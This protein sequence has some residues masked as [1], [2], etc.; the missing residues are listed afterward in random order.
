MG[1]FGGDST[2][3][4]TTNNVS[5]SAGSQT[6]NAPSS[7]VVSEGNVTIN[8]V[9]TDL[10]SLAVAEGIAQD[11]IS[12]ITTVTSDALFNLGSAAGDAVDISLASLDV[13][14][15]VT[16]TALDNSQKTTESVIAGA[17]NIV[18]DVIFG[19]ASAVGDA[20]GL[21]E[22]VASDAIFAVGDAYENSQTNAF[23]FAEGIALEAF[24]VI[25][26]QSA[27]AITLATD[28]VYENTSLVDKV[29]NIISNFGLKSIASAEQSA[30]DAIASAEAA[31]GRALEFGNDA[32]DV[33]SSA[34][35]DQTTVTRSVIDLADDVTAG[36]Q[37]F[38]L[39]ALG[40]AVNT[41]EEL[42]DSRSEESQN[43]LA[44]VTKLGETVSTGGESLRVEANKIFNLAMIAVLGFVAVQAMRG[45]K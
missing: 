23:G 39:E 3:N 1:L 7:S 30:R 16:F 27:G 25:E 15:E 40:T 20:L 12:G 41:I 9:T 11:A 35:A 29:S 34:F 36:N 10:D 32:L 2:T 19:A 21:T 37:L 26:G 31:Q 8:Q 38:L 5:P 33:V 28:V 13:V 6:S 43:V 14:D 44:A 45:S 22:T 17:G 18:G 4:Q 24:E 42:D